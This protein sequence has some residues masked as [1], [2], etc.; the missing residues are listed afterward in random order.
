MAA[1]AII[2]ALAK[3]VGSAIQGGQNRRNRR[4][5]EAQLREEKRID[6][7]RY[8]NDLQQRNLENSLTG[9]AHRMN[10]AFGNQELD[11]RK[12]LSAGRA[13]FAQGFMGS[14]Q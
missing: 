13:A 11:Q 4:S 3:V 9:E 6:E 1:E 8:Q 12:R 10:M 2:A 14:R 5:Q 7:K